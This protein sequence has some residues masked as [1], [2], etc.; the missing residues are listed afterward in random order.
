TRRRPRTRPAARPRRRTRA[1]DYDRV[2]RAVV[3]QRRRR[4]LPAAHQKGGVTVNTTAITVEAIIA[5]LAIALGIIA[6]RA[7]ES[8]ATWADR[9]AENGAARQALGQAIARA[10]VADRAAAR[11]FLVTA[12]LNGVH[13]A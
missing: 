11:A 1:A 7:D 10:A 4:P 9:V 8:L 3:H 6:P 5:D 12:Q 13:H 2:R